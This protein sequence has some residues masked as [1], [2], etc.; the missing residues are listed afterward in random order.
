MKKLKQIITEIKTHQSHTSDNFQELVWQLICYPPKMPIRWHQE[1]LI[2][3]S[4]RFSLTVFDRYF[5]NKDIKFN[6][7]K[8]G[9]GPIKLLITH[10]WGSKAMDFSELIS[11]LR[12]IDEVEI[13]AFDAPG[14]GSSEGELSNL[15]LYT[16][17]IEVIVQKFGDPNIIIGHSLGAMANIIALTE[18]KLAPSL[19]IS[20]TPLIKLKENFEAT[21][22]VVGISQTAKEDFL[23]NF[24][25]KFGVSASYF[26]LGDLY[27]SDEELNHLVIYD[28]ND[29]ISPFSYIKEFLEGHSTIKSKC[30]DNT[31]HDK[32]IKS[33]VLVADLYTIIKDL[34]IK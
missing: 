22:D 14:N 4:E 20:I 27:N 16:Q 5:A 34:I 23:N 13:I 19:L 6:G 15:L 28:H 9:N 33:P 18:M 21:M 12:Q 3:D 17:A 8:W 24:R 11:K 29:Q 10:G 30:Y 31:G 7:F 25:N 1:Q 2:E 32:I 26:T